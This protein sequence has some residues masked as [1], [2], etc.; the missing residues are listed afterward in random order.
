MLMLVKK[1]SHAFDVEAETVNAVDLDAE[2][3][4]TD[5]VL[6]EDILNSAITK[7]E[8]I[9]SINHL[10]AKKAAGPDGLIPEVFKYS[11]EAI[12]PLFLFYRIDSIGYLYQ[13]RIRK[14]RQKLLFTHCTRRVTGTI[15]TTVAVYLC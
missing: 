13:G 5:D 7:Q 14:Q 15:Q 6:E 12:I 1:N 10:K 3:E 4:A 2:T 9:D 8:V 11:Y